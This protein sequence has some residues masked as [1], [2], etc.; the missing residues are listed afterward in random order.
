M[1]MKKI[2][3][4]KLKTQLEEAFGNRPFVLRRDKFR[5][6]IDGLSADVLA[7]WDCLG[8]GPGGRIYIGRKAGYLLPDYLDWLVRRIS[9][10]RT[11]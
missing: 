9:S 5:E 6:S 4:A 11:R 2:D 7:N 10:E 3:Q 1:E 8:K